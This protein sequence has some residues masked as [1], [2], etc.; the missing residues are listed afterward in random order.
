M[1]AN[2]IQILS[3]NSFSI[4]HFINIYVKFISCFFF[5]NMLNNFKQTYSSVLLLCTSQR[6]AGQ[7]DGLALRN[8]RI[9]K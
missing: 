1:D 6:A 7:N 4:L 8:Q 2:S 3:E 5:C 9:Y